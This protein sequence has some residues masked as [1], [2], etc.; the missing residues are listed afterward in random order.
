MV[1]STIVEGGSVRMRGGL[2]GAWAIKKPPFRGKGEQN[3][4][5]GK[6]SVSV[7]DR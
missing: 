7:A 1:K 5:V 3:T 4:Q 6:L 2:L